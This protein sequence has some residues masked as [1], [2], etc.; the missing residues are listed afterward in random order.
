M[1][2]L[3]VCYTVSECNE[4]HHTKAYI[5]EPHQDAKSSARSFHGKTLLLA[6]FQQQNDLYISKASWKHLH[7]I[8]FHVNWL[9]IPI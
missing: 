6:V 4:Q 1:S 8:V 7:K 3:M 5:S 2:L 9:A